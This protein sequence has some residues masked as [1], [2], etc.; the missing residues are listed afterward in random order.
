MEKKSWEI[1]S[2]VLK[3]EVE[4]S[5]FSLLD[6]SIK[7]GID[8]ITL[9]NY[10]N[11]NFDGVEIYVKNHLKKLKDF[12]D[13][14]ED[15]VSLYLNGKE[16]TKNEIYENDK[17]VKEKSLNYLTPY[18]VLSLLSLFLFLISLFLFL[19]V[20][21]LPLVSVS[22]IED[23][24]EING[25]IVKEAKLNEGEYYIKGPALF[26]KIDNKVKRVLVD[27]YQ[28]VVKWEK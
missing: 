25:E 1:L 22:S 7:L 14:E 6:I 5:K 12:F 2:E 20:L 21:N 23:S 11:G 18:L 9:Q 28:V 27:V 8:K 10:L 24:I 13:I 3:K 15:L 17:K 16:E 4:S 19:K 26:K